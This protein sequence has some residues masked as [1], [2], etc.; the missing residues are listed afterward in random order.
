[1]CS[2]AFDPLPS[3]PQWMYWRMWLWWRGWSPSKLQATKS[4]TAAACHV[5]PRQAGGPSAVVLPRHNDQSSPFSSCL[6][7]HLLDNDATVF[8]VVVVGPHQKYHHVPYH[9]E[10]TLICLF[11]TFLVFPICFSHTQGVI[12]YFYCFFQLT[13]S[14]FRKKCPLAHIFERFFM[15]HSKCP[16]TIVL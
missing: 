3:S 16:I 7:P 2:P 13:S 1:M 4:P 6:L 10:N 11:V 5:P 8:V 15:S 12:S 14:A 9:L